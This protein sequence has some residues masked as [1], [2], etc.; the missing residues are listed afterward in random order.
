MESAKP[1][2]FQLC[3]ARVTGGWGG[4]CTTCYTYVNV[5]AN[6]SRRSDRQRAERFVRDSGQVRPD[7]V[8][9]RAA[10]LQREEQG[11]ERDRKKRTELMKKT[12]A[13]AISIDQ[14]R[15]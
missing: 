13:E 9:R 6:A 7:N 1:A 10:R 2:C 11:I 14:Q 4:L 15:L 5:R 3:A 8:E 12:V